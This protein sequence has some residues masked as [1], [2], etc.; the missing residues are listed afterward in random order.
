[1]G[2]ANFL[3]VADSKLC[4]RETL[5]HIHEQRGR[6][7]TV[8]PR[9]RKEDA[10]FKAWLQTHPPAWE[11]VARK[12]HPRWQHGPPDLF[13]AIPSPIPDADGFRLFWYESSHKME[14]D[15]QARRDALQA[16]WT[17]LEALAAK[18]HGPRPRGRTRAAVAAAVEGILAS[19]GAARWVAYQVVPVVS[20]DLLIGS[21]L[22][23]GASKRELSR[24]ISA[25]SPAPAA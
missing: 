14:R 13:R 2:S 23:L 5:K 16:A 1:M 22:A 15:A 8:L 20:L 9:T 17:A 10:R 18:I 7:I 24:I 21:L 4:T 3:Y 25:R 12:P 19:T 6:F 11:E